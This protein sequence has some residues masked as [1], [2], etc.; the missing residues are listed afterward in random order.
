MFNFLASRISHLL[1]SVFSVVDVQSRLC[2]E[3]MLLRAFPWSAGDMCETDEM[4]RAYF[5]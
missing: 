5:S 1:N 4:K 2:V 3:G